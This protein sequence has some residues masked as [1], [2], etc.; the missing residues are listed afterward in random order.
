MRKLKLRQVTDHHL[1]SG[2]GRY[3]FELTKAL[4][5]L[6]YETRLSKLYKK[7]GD[8][9]EFDRRHEWIEKIYYKSLKNLHSYLLPY[10]IGGHMLPKRADIYHAHWFMAGLGLAKAGK[11]NKVITMHDVSLLHETEQKGKFLNYYTKAIDRFAKEGTPI[12]V[13][14]ESAK[15]DALKYSNLREEQL[16]AVHN[17]VNFEQFFTKEKTKPTDGTFQL[18][19]AG[20]LSPRKNVDLL[21]KSCVILESRG[22]EYRLRIAGNHPDR[23]PYP[24]LA[25]ELKLKNVSFTGFIADDKMN[26]FYNDADLFVYTSKYEG[27]GFTPLEA[28]ASG[29]PVLTTSGGSLGEVSGGGAQVVEY[30]EESLAEA[31]ISIIQDTKVRNALASKGAKWVKQYSWENC[32]K[33]TLKVYE[34][35]TI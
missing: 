21:L 17:G 4:I 28:M 15:Q 35:I 26:D 1:N 9:S 24:A 3:S 2:I 5:D 32:A 33:N 12:I 11:K 16:F 13:V 25:H 34:T 7:G 10:F 22:V 23:T 30:D 19:Y 6:G 31:V 18:V 27:F 29:T 14:S 20:G 8:D